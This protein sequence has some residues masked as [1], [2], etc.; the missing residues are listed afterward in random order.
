MRFA[1]QKKS[2]GSVSVFSLNRKVI[3]RALKELV[4][5]LSARD[6]VCVIILFGSSARGTSTPGSDLDILVVLEESAVPF[7]ERIPD[8]TPDNFP[9][10]VD[11]F[12]YTVDELADLGP[13]VRHAVETGRLLWERVPGTLRNLMLTRFRE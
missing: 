13:F 9:L 4:G 1:V 5:W 10:P 2:F 7:L 12:P 3:E 11:L 6:E 8:Y